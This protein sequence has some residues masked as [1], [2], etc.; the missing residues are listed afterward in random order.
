MKLFGISIPFT[1]KRASPS[2]ADDRWFSPFPWV[3]LG[4]DK[5]VTPE[6]AIA[7][8]AVYACVKI[9]SETLSSVPLVVYK[10]RDDG[11][12]DRDTRN[13]LSNLLRNRPN[14]Y[15]TGF[16][17]REALTAQVLLWGNGYAQILRNNLNEP[18]EL[19]PMHPSIVTPDIV[20]G[21]VVYKVRQKSGQDR[22]LRQDEVFHL[23]GYSDTG[24]V[25]LSPIAVMRQAISMG[26]SLENFGNNFFEGGAFPAGVLE[27]EGVGVLGDAARDNLRDSWQKLY[28]GE[29]R[30]KKVAVLEAGVKWKPMGIPQQDAQFLET[31]KFQIQEIARCFRV[32]PHMLA[33]LDRATFSNI[34]HLSQEFITYCMLPWFRRWEETITWSLLDGDD[35]VNF[36]EFLVD[37][38]L[39]GDTTTRFQAYVLAIQNG[40]MNR[41]EVRL[42]ENLNPYDGGDDFL[43]PLNMSTGELEDDTPEEES[44]DVEEED[45]TEPRS[46]QEPVEERADE[47]PDEAEKEKVRSAF[48]GVLHDTWGRIARKE[49]SS[50]KTAARKKGDEFDAWFD[51]F[52]TDF[53]GFVVECLKEPVKGYCSLRG[54]DGDAA[55]SSI[56]DEYRSSIKDSVEEWKSE[57]A[58]GYARRE[59]EIASFWTERVL[60]YSQSEHEHA[61]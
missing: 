52:V 56:V 11:G 55:L 29:N 8:S 45:T 38:L 4:N 34:E 9:I 6:T 17:F 28:G 61:D 57:P 35:S 44:S 47:L 54:I 10:R 40:I 46:A 50:I 2:V 14:R 60:S 58:K 13:R 43:T 53:R 30:G 22:I 51:E 49:V 20:G 24:L 37:G 41:N 18:I 39:R 59:D 48:K 12:K 42:R 27:Y 32:P 36:A 26:I 25:G 19:I 21:D 23:K 16:Q 1:T 3:Y 5:P 33:D 7:F 31:R 15:M